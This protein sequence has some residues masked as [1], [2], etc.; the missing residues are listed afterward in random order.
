MLAGLALT[1]CEGGRTAAHSGGPGQRN[2]VPDS[3]ARR[4]VR[5]AVDAMG[6]E[7]ILRGLR[8]LRLRGV[9][10]TAM[11]GVSPDSEPP[12]LL[13][14]SFD[15][16]RDVR[17]A[18]ALRHAE[19]RMVMRAD[20]IP[21]TQVIDTATSA[22]EAAESVAYAPERL[23]LQALDAPDLAMAPD[24][25]LPG[26]AVRVVRFGTPSVRIY[27]D[28]VSGLP[29]GWSTVRTY[30]R[31][32]NVWAPWGDVRSRTLFGSWALEPTGFRYPRTITVMRNGTPY[33]R[34]SLLSVHEV[35]ASPDSF[36]TTPGSGPPGPVRLGNGRGSGPVE[37]APGVVLVPGAYNVELVRQEDGVV[38][39]EAPHSG[40]YSR[41]VLEAIARR[42]P[43]LPVKA[44]VSTTDA[45]PHDA[46][47][48]EYVARGVP[49][50]APPRGAALVRRL[51]SA[52]Y[53]LE[54]DSLQRAPRSPDLRVVHDTAVVG[55][56]ANRLIL[57]AVVD[58]SGEGGRL[59]VA[60]L[61]GRRLLYAGDLLIPRR[62]EPEFWLGAWTALLDGVRRHD[63]TVDTV[64]ALHDPPVALSSVREAVAASD[65]KG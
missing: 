48:R 20:P 59:L 16:L 13:H 46:G 17:S 57:A 38:V 37:L 65:A 21:V 1:A 40:A 62:F 50:Y 27:L 49:I 58:P 34:I 6:G 18:R 9:E 53:R 47:V 2:A 5:R 14:A 44:L 26:G 31:D 22:F 23:L 63:W 41:R 7:G 24:T 51:A 45:W 52:P 30:P 19:F 33:R 15:E 8:Y 10:V 55:S 11:V 36:P 42:W 4:L 35:Q 64:T 3:A 12:R 32:L 29:R 60:Y 54:P 25:A 43:G 56:G 61:P 39:L 28:P